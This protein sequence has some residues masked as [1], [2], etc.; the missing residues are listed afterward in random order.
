MNLV[1]AIIV[2]NA[3]ETSKSDNQHI[4]QEKMR[5]EQKEMKALKRLFEMM[6]IDGSGT[7]SWEE[8]HGSFQDPKM[9]EK[10]TLLDFKPADD[11][12]IFQLLDDG[13]GEIDVGE[14]FEGLSRIKGMASA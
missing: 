3:M 12:E 6:D 10:W 11:K 14:F 9:Y 13:D 2:E 8:F 7:L 5:V 4:V 1:T